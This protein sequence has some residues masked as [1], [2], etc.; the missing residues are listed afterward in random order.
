M[1]VSTLFLVYKNNINCLAFELAHHQRYGGVDKQTTSNNCQ[2][3]DSVNYQHCS[4]IPIR[5]SPMRSTSIS[6]SAASPDATTATTTND[7][8][9]SSR[10]NSLFCSENAEKRRQVFKNRQIVYDVVRVLLLLVSLG[11][12]IYNILCYFEFNRCT[13]S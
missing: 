5:I 10:N 6:A 11:N 13:H 2:M 3:D 8:N 1:Y 12:Y 4:R 9:H 7:S